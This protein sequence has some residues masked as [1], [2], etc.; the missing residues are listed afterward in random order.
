MKLF[1]GNGLWKKIGVI[2]GTITAILVLYWQVSDR[3]DTKIAMANSNLETKVAMTL[4]Q[5]QQRQDVLRQ[6]DDIKL[7]N[8]KIEVLQG[9]INALKK[10]LRLNPNDLELQRELDYKLRKLDE[11]KKQLNML[12]N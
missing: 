3:M 1:N 4:D 2:V 8:L 9:Q 11:A 7:L 6:K 12:L 5:F 10:Q